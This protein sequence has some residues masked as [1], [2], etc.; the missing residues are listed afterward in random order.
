LENI[1]DVLSRSSAAGITKWI[2]PAVDEVSAAKLLR[3]STEYENI[4]VALGVHAVDTETE[5]TW[6]EYPREKIEEIGTILEQKNPKVVAIGECGLDFQYAVTVKEQEVQIAIFEQHCKWAVQYN[7]PLIIHN[8]KAGEKLIEV[9]TDT[10]VDPEKCVFHCFASSRKFARK[11]IELGSYFG[12][13]GLLT[14]DTGLQEVAKEIP[15]EKIV[16]ETD[17][18]YLTPKPVR[19]DKPFPNEPANM[20]FVARKLGEIKE[21]A[22]EKLAIITNE[23]TQKLFGI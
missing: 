3:L 23:N 2:A 1:K 19:R 20:L 7:L 16:L 18:P 22:V 10:G 9:I 11:L 15:L 17:A 6:L 5:S 21:V 4:Y 12:I 14:M 13:G 8:R